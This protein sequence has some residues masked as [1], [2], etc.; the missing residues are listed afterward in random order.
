MPQQGINQGLSANNSGLPQG[1]DPSALGLNQQQANM[2]MSDPRLR[3]QLLQQLQNPNADVANFSDYWDSTYGPNGWGV[4]PSL[5]SAGWGALAGLGAYLSL[6]HGIYKKWGS[7]HPLIVR[8]ANRFENLPGIR[9]A[10]QW[11]DEKPM[12]WLYDKANKHFVPELTEAD[13]ANTTLSADKQHRIK[14]AKHYINRFF[15]KASHIDVQEQSVLDS[16]YSLK[17]NFWDVNTEN[18]ETYEKLIKFV[19]DKAIDYRSQT[20]DMSSAQLEKFYKENNLVNEFQ[21][22]LNTYETRLN[23]AAR[24]SEHVV[25]VLGKQVNEAKIESI[26]T[27]AEQMELYKKKSSAKIKQYAK[28][29]EKNSSQRTLLTSLANDVEADSKFVELQKNLTKRLGKIEGGVGGL[30]TQDHEGHLVKSLYDKQ[31]KEHALAKHAQNANRLKTPGFVSRSIMKVTDMMREVFSGR[32]FGTPKGGKKGLIMSAGVAV[33]MGGLMTFG[34]AFDSASRADKGEKASGFFHNLIGEGI[35]NFV[36]WIAFQNALNGLNVFPRVLDWMGKM[37]EKVIKPNSWLGERKIVKNFMSTSIKRR[38]LLL[39]VMGF[40]TAG[41]L[42][43]ITSAFLGGSIFQKIGEGFSNLIF[44]EPEHIKRE[45]AAMEGKFPAER[46]DDNSDGLK[47]PDSFER[48]QQPRPQAGLLTQPPAGPPATMV[49]SSPFQN[50]T[51]GLGH[52]GNQAAPKTNEQSDMLAQLL[53]MSN[54]PSPMTQPASNTSVSKPLISPTPQG[55]SK[56]SGAVNTS[57]DRPQPKQRDF[58]AAL[59]AK[60]QQKHAPHVAE[61]REEIE[62]IAFSNE[63]LKA[64]EQSQAYIRE[65]EYLKSIPM[66]HFDKRDNWLES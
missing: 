32:M 20:A 44:G 56:S 36:G 59:K 5:K 66:N 28:T 34:F 53:A 7:E 21:K 37:K 50:K 6:D 12:K 3:Q 18:K 47:H 14:R 29:F 38:K 42:T 41:L 25:N 16:M 33:L 60:M 17:R 57:A 35:M 19:K 39:G 1:L 48:L 22:E 65:Q 23:G 8:M 63:Q 58:M 54:Q 46:F 10:S 51:S 40:T 2:L 13:R 24:Q 31:A 55:Q 30:K 49:A 52:P 64:I 4:M 11:I 27:K 15:N 9:Q 62:P 61:I 43:F 45:R 26:L